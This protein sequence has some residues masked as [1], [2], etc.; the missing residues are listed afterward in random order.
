MPTR[1]RIVLRW[2][3]DLAVVG[4][5]IACIVHYS[6]RRAVACD[7]E[8]MRASCTVEA[9][10]SLGRVQHEDI[11]GIR[12]AA[13]RHGAIVGLV[14]DAQ[15]KDDTALFGTRDVQLDDVA[16]AERLRA[17]AADRDP[18]H[19]SIESGVA[20]PRMTTG[21]ILA[22]LLAYGFVTRR[23]RSDLATRDA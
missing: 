11:H 5:A 7:W 21:A 13:Y 8:R 4:V 9:E 23:R 18:D 17:F 6:R 15:N 10:D 16:S 2:L 22:A 1:L 3:V 19:V 14:T 12:G 20:R